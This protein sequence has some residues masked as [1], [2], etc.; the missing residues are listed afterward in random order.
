M[1]L[2][3]TVIGG[4][5]GAGKTSVVNHMLRHADG[6]RLAVLVNEFGAL[7]IDEDLIEAEDDDILSIA[8][9]CVCCSYGNELVAALM[10]LAEMDPAPDHVVLE[11]SG[12]AL[13]GA[14][15]ASVSLISGYRLDGIVTL[16]DAE[17]IETRCRDRWVG[18][19]ARRQLDDADLVVLNKADLVTEAALE[20]T[21][22]WLNAQA[23]LA[24]VIDARHGQVPL[25]VLLGSG[26]GARPVP[27]AAVHG[28]MPAF[29]SHA[30][31]VDGPVAAE[32]LAR[33]LAAEDLGLVRAKGF[34]RDL[35]GQ[36]RA[37]QTVG[38]RWDVTEAAA[39]KPIGLVVIGIGGALDMAAV[40]DALEAARAAPSCDAPRSQPASSSG[41][42]SGDA[43]SAVS[44]ADS[45]SDGSNSL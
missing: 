13:P 40:E 2:P 43:S 14:I 10:K 8:G 18:D 34:V 22:D 41:S 15:A 28:D 25:E 23:P 26:G 19:T 31:E 9:G 35:S 29:E 42:L 6:A 3:L 20:T 4:Y 38:K 32:E 44:A 5:L 36:T 11:A 7:A 27:H 39:S 12:V 1:T 21:R 45:A 37:I 16:A 30:L 24:R 17:T 33:A